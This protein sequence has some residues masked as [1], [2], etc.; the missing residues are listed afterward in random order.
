MNLE[1]LYVFKATAAQQCFQND[2]DEIIILQQWKI[3]QQKYKAAKACLA[4]RFDKNWT[5]QGETSG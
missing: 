4:S 1:S 2:A 3:E 5:S